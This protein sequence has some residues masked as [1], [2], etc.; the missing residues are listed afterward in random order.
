MP[1]TPPCLVCGACCFSTLETYVRVTGDDHARLADD[2]E[3]LSVFVGNR[4]YMRMLSGHCAALA[5]GADDTFVCGVYE[6]RPE[7][8]RALARESPACQ[9]ERALKADRPRAL[10]P[11]ISRRGTVQRPRHGRMGALT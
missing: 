1:I 8:C 7:V 5:V 9:A 4:M 11:Q 10:L 3:A 6:R 2:A